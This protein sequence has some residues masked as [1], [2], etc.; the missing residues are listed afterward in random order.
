M[1]GEDDL[2]M[3][4]AKETADAIRTAR[5]RVCSALH[6]STHRIE[7]SARLRQER[8]DSRLPMIKDDDAKRDIKLAQLCDDIAEALEGAWQTAE[9]FLTEVEGING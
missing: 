9:E 2:L 5:L 7:W 4:S 8:H 1:L 3:A 6:L